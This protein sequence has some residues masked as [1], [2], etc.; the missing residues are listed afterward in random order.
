MFPIIAVDIS[1]RHKIKDGYYMVCAAVALEVSAS[2]IESI[3]QV[4]IKPFL[5]HD[6]LAVLDIVRIIEVT[7]SEI[8]FP[9]TIVVEKGD[10]YNQPE[11][12]SKNM[13]SRD[14]KYQ[15]SLSEMLAIEFAHYVSLS[16]RKLLMKELDI[17]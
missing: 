16:S 9:G 12:L 6:P 15:E 1:G 11:W 8:A 7:V 2:H 10:L 17:E 13:F 5:S 3:S 14:I 4:A